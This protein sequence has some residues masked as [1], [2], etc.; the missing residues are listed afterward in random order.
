VSP[1]PKDS[2]VK[3]AIDRYEA[4]WRATVEL[5]RG[6]RSWSG[7]ERDCVFLNGH[8]PR[9]ATIS[10]LTG[11]DL[12][13]DGRSLARVDWD[14]D[15]DL[16]LWALNRNGPRLRLM[17]NRAAD[18]GA[19]QYV[20]L[21][22]R[23]TTANRDAIGARVEI[24]LEGEKGPRLV[25]TL[26]AGEGFLSQSSKWLHFGLGAGAPIREAKVRWPGG[27][28]E[29][30]T[31]IARGGRF[32]LVEGSGRAEAQPARGRVA[33]LRPA[34]QTPP[35]PTQAARIQLPEKTL[36]PSLAGVTAHQGKP[37]LVSLWASWCPPC[38]RELEEYTARA[39]EL[40]AAGVEVLALTVDGLDDA[41]GAG[42]EKAEEFLR[43][44]R[45]PFA[46]GRA[47]FELLDKLDRFQLGLFDRVPPL[48]VPTAF[49]L[50][51]EDRAAAIYRGSAP[52]EA[53]LEDVARLDIP[54]EQRRDLAAPF[55]GRW[56]ARP[57]APEDY[58]IAVAAEFE[59]GSYREEVGRYV[60][61]A[62][63][64]LQ[65]RVDEIS[66]ATDR[67]RAL[68]RVAALRLRAGIIHEEDG[69]PE[70]AIDQLRQAAA[71]RP[72]EPEIHHHLGRSLAADGRGK[73][74]QWEFL[75]A[76]ETA[77]ED[78]EIYNDLGVALASMGRPAEGAPAFREALTLRPGFLEAA[79]NLARAL[80]AQGLSQE[81]VDAYR[82]ATRLAPSAP[83][84][85]LELG[86]ILAASPDPGRRDPAEAIRLAESA[87]TLEGASPF[88]CLDLLAAAY[89]AAGRFEEAVV[90]GEEAGRAADQEADPAA[91]R[92]IRARVA[93]YRSRVPFVTGGRRGSAG[94]P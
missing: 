2:K 35:P 3:A 12:S 5:V 72:K 4:A 76:L 88:R 52:V 83:A 34:V 57:A 56:L 46:S 29:T 93:L 60:T 94:G 69:R 74:A 64:A 54:P 70:P 45:F 7:N 81:A 71:I 67:E 89:A 21:Q 63:D 58:L 41:K 68:D 43:R 24:V 42:P 65:L 27:A 26:A 40:Q 23:G 47:T 18:L 84:P 77:P 9:F 28:T 66:R 62:A 31:G 86:W 49:L 53:I 33:A 14:Q 75:R 8:G 19:T 30:F 16:D 37:R 80:Q 51:G 48:A 44:I 39:A 32:L 38:L 11:L 55:P 82:E 50:D 87:R 90:T 36:F 1:S 59:R 73:E 22:L 85:L 91:A 92:S 79:L 25:Q 6:G 13:D 78:A 15:G 20:A 61:A 10:A 17:L